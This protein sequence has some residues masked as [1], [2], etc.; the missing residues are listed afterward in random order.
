MD[1]LLRQLSAALESHNTGFGEWYET[2]ARI[3]LLKVAKFPDVRRLYTDDSWRV[4]KEALLQHFAEHPSPG[5]KVWWVNT[6][7]E[8]S[9][10]KVADG[11]S[12][13]T[14]EQIPDGLTVFQ[15][16]N[17]ASINDAQA[18]L[19]R[20]F[21][22]EDRRPT[23]WISMMGTRQLAITFLFYTAAR[24]I[25]RRLIVGNTKDG[26][27]TYENV[28]LEAVQPVCRDVIK[29][30]FNQGYT[31]LAAFL[32]RYARSVAYMLGCEFHFVENCSLT[33]I[34][35]TAGA[36]IK[37]HIDGVSSFGDV[38]GPILTLA[39]GTGGGKV[40]DLVPT[41]VQ[42][43][44]AAPVRVAI[45]PYQTIMMQ[46]QARAEWVHSIPTG[47]PEAQYTVAFKLGN[48]LTAKNVEAAKSEVLGTSY[49]KIWI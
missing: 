39:M 15:P 25:V 36:G 44:R 14:T 13:S 8:G 6:Q 32:L 5:G 28:E 7:F 43:P 3:A 24:S 30:L 34:R 35:Y 49:P 27:P 37:R 9:N 40:M 17:D 47:N 26:E 19:T 29:I 16:Y 12:K 23:P 48:V 46:G 42:D 18:E 31:V 33:L 11:C 21:R 45:R 10:S 2:R 4:P 38:F 41:L 20:L 1:T 22:D